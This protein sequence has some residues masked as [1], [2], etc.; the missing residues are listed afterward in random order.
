MKRSR[1][2]SDREN[3]M[4]LPERTKEF[5]ESSANITPTSEFMKQRIRPLQ[6]KK[7]TSQLKNMESSLGEKPESVNLILCKKKNTIAINIVNY[8]LVDFLC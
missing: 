7:L 1:P 3:L 6:E 5:K 8:F 2:K 4:P